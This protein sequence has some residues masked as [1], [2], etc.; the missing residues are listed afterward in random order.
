MFI[1]NQPHGYNDGM[2]WPKFNLKQLFVSM[3][4]MSA[5]MG[6]IAYSFRSLDGRSIE[7]AA[8]KV[9]G[10]VVIIVGALLLVTKE[11]RTKAL[12]WVLGGILVGYFIG[13]IIAT[14]A[15]PGQRY[16]MGDEQQLVDIILYTSAAL[17]ALI[18]FTIVILSAARSNKFTAAG[19][20]A[21][22]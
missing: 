6:A 14:I 17:G 11:R 3:F 2:N 21:P 10:V 12:I 13:C 15:M 7:C 5:G 9:L 1:P 18:G 22:K 16:R 20:F 8:G 4:L 19:D